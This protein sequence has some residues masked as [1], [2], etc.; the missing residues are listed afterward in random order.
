M[1]REMQGER[2]PLLAREGE[3]PRLRVKDDGAAKASRWSRVAMMASGAVALGVVATHARA[4]VFSGPAEAS[5]G[6]PVKVE[7]IAP[8]A[9]QYKGPVFIHIPKNGGTSIELLAAYNG[10]RYVARAHTDA[11]ATTVS[12][13]EIALG[14]LGEYRWG[15]VADVHAVL[16]SVTPR[17]ASHKRFLF[18]RAYSRRATDPSHRSSRRRR[19]V[20]EHADAR[21]PSSPLLLSVWK[22]IWHVR[23]NRPRQLRVRVRVQ[24]NTRFQL[25]RV[26]PSAAA[27][28]VHLPRREAGIR[29]HRR[30]VL[31]VTQPLRPAGESVSTQIRP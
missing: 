28:I 6:L 31:Y 30:F 15:P 27:P 11:S 2:V 3:A 9:N 5:L 12:S 26:A 21:L 1:A 24:D 10:V 19:F 14:P 13:E 7:E 16:P 20:P 17:H 18:A 4:G 25:Q 23:G 22:K 29:R 8:Y